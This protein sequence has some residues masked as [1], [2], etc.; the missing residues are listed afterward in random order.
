MGG[1]V[2]YPLL[3]SALLCNESFTSVIKLK[4]VIEGGV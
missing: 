1:E 4:M 3:F 2:S